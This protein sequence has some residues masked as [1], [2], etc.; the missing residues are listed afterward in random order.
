LRTKT[1]DQGYL[2]FTVKSALK[3][4]HEYRAK[5]EAIGLV[6][7]AN[8]LILDLA[9]SDFTTALSKSQY[10]RGGYTSEQILRSIVVMFIEEESYRD[11]VILVENS[12]FLRNFIR[13]GNKTM[14]DFTFLCKAYTALSEKTW[15]AMNETLNGYAKKEKKITAEKLRLDTTAYETN[16]HYP[17]DSSLLWDSYRTLARVMS[18][19]RDDLRAVGCVH[20]FHTKKIKKLAQYIGRNSDK[21]DKG[22]QRKI[23]STYR[24]LIERVK[25]IVSVG[26]A[27]GQLLS[28]C[29]LHAM[30]AAVELKHYLP[31][32]GKVIGQA[33]RRVLLGQQVPSSEKIYSLFEDHTELIKRGK[34]RKP[35]EFGHKVVLAET[36]EKF[37]IHYETMS[38]QRADTELIEESLNAHKKVF[39]CRPDLLAGDKGFYESREQITNLSKNIETVSIC[40]KGRRTAEEDQRESTKKFKTGQRFRAGIEG[41]ISVLKR[42]FKLSKCLFKGFKNF[43]SSVGCAVFCHNLVMLART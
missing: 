25:W 15:K 22:V 23:K 14:M 3:V 40:K 7:D 18:G 41:T 1:S 38:K 8:A 30:V 39:R 6:L 32:T 20:R 9:H 16:I 35:I 37:I 11:T 10:G 26:E 27:A 21:K 12:A 2:D 43:A 29:S 42:A 17:T 33:E 19:V 4:V 24:T 36:G 34:A 28:G 31:I 5:Y 13:L